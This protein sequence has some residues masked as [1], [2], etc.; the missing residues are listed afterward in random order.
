MHM[1]TNILHIESFRHHTFSLSLSL[2]QTPFDELQ[3]DTLNTQ[4]LKYAKTVYQLEKG[5]PPNGVVPKL[6]AKVEDMKDKVCVL[7]VCVCV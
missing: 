3:P 5:L 1:Y 2:T 7:C 4:V 6:K